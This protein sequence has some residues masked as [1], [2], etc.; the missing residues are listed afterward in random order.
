MTDMDTILAVPRR[1]ACHAGPCGEAAGL[2]RKQK[3]GG[4]RG[5][6]LLGFSQAG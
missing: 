3:D 5:Q 1:W 6:S 2:V 4:G